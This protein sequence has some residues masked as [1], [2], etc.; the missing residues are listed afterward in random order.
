MTI[1]NTVFYHQMPFNVAVIIEQLSNYNGLLR[2][3]ANIE[4]ASCSMKIN[5]M[6]E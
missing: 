2:E 3:Q 5:T 4:K 6:S 1:H